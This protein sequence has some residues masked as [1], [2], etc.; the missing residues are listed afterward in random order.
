MVRGQAPTP[1]GSQNQMR[2]RANAPAEAFSI[3][4]RVFNSRRGFAFGDT[5]RR[6]R[7]RDQVRRANSLRGTRKANSVAG[8]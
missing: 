4:R 7:A 3:S 6:N 2:S 8:P 5:Y 1:P